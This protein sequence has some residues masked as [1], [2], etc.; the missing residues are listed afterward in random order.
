MLGVLPAPLLPDHQRTSLR[1]CNSLK[2][3]VKITSHNSHLLAPFSRALVFSK[4]SLLGE[5]S[6]RRHPIKEVARQPTTVR[7]A[8][9]PSRGG[10]LQCGP[11]TGR[12][13]SRRRS[14]AP[15]LPLRKAPRGLCNSVGWP[16]DRPDVTRH[17]AYSRDWHPYGR[18]DAQQRRAEI[19]DEAGRPP[20]GSGVGGRHPRRFCTSPA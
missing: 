3:R 4:P 9:G 16:G 20:G 1:H 10:E 11:L 17:P 6:Q 14:A 18:G 13:N 8:H 15:C 19:G 2:T 12:R 7:Q 5:G